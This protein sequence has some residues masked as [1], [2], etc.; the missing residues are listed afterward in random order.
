MFHNNWL[1]NKNLPKMYT[2]VHVKKKLILNSQTKT[3]KSMLS[4]T[5]PTL[6]IVRKNCFTKIITIFNTNKQVP[7]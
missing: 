7:V 2:C 5:L 4:F 6:S 3:I 1:L